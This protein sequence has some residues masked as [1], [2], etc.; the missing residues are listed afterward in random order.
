MMSTELSIYTQYSN[1]TKEKYQYQLLENPSDIA[2][3]A[4][5]NNDITWL[6]LDTEFIGEKRYSTLLCLIQV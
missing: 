4:A 3:F 5:A 1:M 2:A 6:C